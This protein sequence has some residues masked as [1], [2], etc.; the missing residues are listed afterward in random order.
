M[1][2]EISTT[3]RVRSP[4]PTLLTS[5]FDLGDCTSMLMETQR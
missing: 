4:S 1:G 3:G 5:P 2:Y